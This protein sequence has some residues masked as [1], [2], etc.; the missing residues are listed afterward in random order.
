[1]TEVEL[2]VTGRQS[3]F[4]PLPSGKEHIEISLPPPLEKMTVKIVNLGDGY[5]IRVSFNDLISP[6][7]YHEDVKLKS[8]GKEFKIN[9]N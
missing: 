9:E 1:M 2:K 6:I 4:L 3:I 5:N 8:D 7:N